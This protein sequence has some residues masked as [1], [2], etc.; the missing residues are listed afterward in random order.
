M[1]GGLNIHSETTPPFDPCE[2]SDKQTAQS[3]VIGWGA[4]ALRRCHGRPASRQ[5]NG[6]VFSVN[7]PPTQLPDQ[8]MLAAK[9][10]ELYALKAPVSG[11]DQHPPASGSAPR[12]KGGQA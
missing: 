9:L 12:Q 3:V 7:E 11:T 2:T 1:F 5:S 8:Q 6:A 4:G 10:Y